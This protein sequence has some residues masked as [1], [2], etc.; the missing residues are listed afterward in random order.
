VI[1]PV[2]VGCPLSQEPSSN[3]PKSVHTY[4]ECTPEFIGDRKPIEATQVRRKP[5]WTNMGCQG[6]L[7]VLV[8]VEVNLYL[9]FRLIIRATIHN[10]SNFSRQLESLQRLKA[11]IVFS[12]PVGHEYSIVLLSTPYCP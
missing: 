1:N 2:E 8:V 9:A 11:E 4:K 12:I 6:A 3:P 7:S 5:N 10:F